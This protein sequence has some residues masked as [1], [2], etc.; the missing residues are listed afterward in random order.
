GKLFIGKTRIAKRS[1]QLE[2]AIDKTLYE[3]RAELEQTR[4]LL[5]MQLQKVNQQL[6][7]LSS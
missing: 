4:E 7:K 3:D 5:E 6:E 2:A 1:Q